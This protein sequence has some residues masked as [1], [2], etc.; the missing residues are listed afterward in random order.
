MRDI[1]KN[2]V[3]SILMSMLFCLGKGV[4]KENIYSNSSLNSVCDEKETCLYFGGMNNDSIPA[5][6]SLIG[7]KIKKNSIYYDIPW[8][9][10][11]PKLGI[12]YEGYITGKKRVMSFLLNVGL[13]MFYVPYISTELKFYYLNSGNFYVYCSAG[14]L[15]ARPRGIIEFSKSSN[16]VPEAYQREF[17]RIYPLLSPWGIVYQKRRFTFEMSTNFTYIGE[18]YSSAIHRPFSF[19]TKIPTLLYLN[20]RVGF[21]F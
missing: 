6:D 20:L 18:R 3:I 11:L 19:N 17:S 15:A 14:A 21:C 2:W 7:D 13:L 1:L 9:V 8:I 16:K 12:C 4:S 10:W 5:K